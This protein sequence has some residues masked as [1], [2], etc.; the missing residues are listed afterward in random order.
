MIIM[1]N[2]HRVSIKTYNKNNNKNVSYD[3]PNF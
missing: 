2:F 3:D 1:T